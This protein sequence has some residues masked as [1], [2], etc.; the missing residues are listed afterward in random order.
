VA[1]DR[2][3]AGLVGAERYYPAGPA[4]VGGVLAPDAQAAS[5]GGAAS[6]HCGVGLEGRARL[7][8]RQRCGV[9]AVASAAAVAAVAGVEP[10]AV[11]RAGRSSGS[12]VGTG[13]GAPAFLA[14]QTPRRTMQNWLGMTATKMI[15]TS[16]TRTRSTLV[17]AVCAAA[18]EAR[19]PSSVHPPPSCPGTRYRCDGDDGDDGNGG[20]GGCC[21]VGV[22]S[23]CPQGR[24]LRR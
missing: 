23:A 18:A 12:R 2:A 5:V 8:W 1:A 13:R 15:L 19:S 14:G 24:V 11:Q 6:G 20:R 21:D 10:C 7:S 16:P 9:R 3:H 17:W 22:V 4:G